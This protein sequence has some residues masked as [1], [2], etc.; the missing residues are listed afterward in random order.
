MNTTFYIAFALKNNISHNFYLGI[1]SSDNE[2]FIREIES[3]T[4]FRNDSEKLREYIFN[5]PDVYEDSE[6]LVEALK[7]FDKTDFT[8]H[9]LGKYI[10]ESQA[11]QRIQLSL[12]SY[13]R[14]DERVNYYCYNI[15]CVVPNDIKVKKSTYNTTRQRMKSANEQ[16]TK[17]SNNNNNKSEVKKQSIT[18][19]ETESGKE[20]FFES[21]GDCMAFLNCSFSTFSRFLKG[22]T[23]L[24]KKYIIK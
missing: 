20:I 11:E 2:D 18:L 9:K 14:L 6:S 21:K 8:A 19:I 3:E 24:N 22:D 10:E 15:Y 16:L 1:I 23:K 4:Q 17:E 12:D 5:N 13:K 7:T